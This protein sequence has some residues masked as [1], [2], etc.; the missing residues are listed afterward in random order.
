M[1]MFVGLFHSL[2][3]RGVPVTFNEWLLLQ[4]ALSENLMDSSLTRF[5]HLARAI[6]V[7]TEAHFDKYDQAFLECFGHIESDEDLIR[8][9]EER[10][11]KMPP[12]ELTEEEKRMVEQ[13]SLEEV[14][15]CLDRPGFSPLEIMPR[16]ARTKLAAVDLPL[17]EDVHSIPP[18]R[19]L[20]EALFA[21]SRTRS[22][23]SSL[24]RHRCE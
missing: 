16:E 1:G 20:S 9:V 18:M 14:R 7:K 13:L 11:A 5:Y 4:H 22:H 8:A 10:L 24:R 15:D 12:L 6:L 3:R 2:K 23:S 21:I 19:G 17:I